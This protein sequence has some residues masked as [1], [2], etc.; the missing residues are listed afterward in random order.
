M[1]ILFISSGLMPDYQCDSLFHG[2]REVFGNGV[3]DI[4]KV[5]YMYKTFPLSEKPNLYGKGFT[6]YGLLEDESDIDRSDIESKIKHRFFDFI[7]Y[8]SIHRCQ[9]YVE[10]VL[11]IYPPENI[12]FIDGE[13]DGKV[14]N[15]LLNRG[16]YFKRELQA[17]N[18][19]ILPIHFSVPKDK[20]IND[21]Y[22]LEKLSFRSH[23][24]PR[25]R[26]TYIYEKEE[27]YYQQYQESFFGF[28]TKKAGW[29]CLRHYEI[30][31]QGCAP[32]FPDLLDCPYLTM[33]RF[34]RLETIRLMEIA[35]YCVQN[36]YLDMEGYLSNLEYLF[37]YAKKYLTTAAVA[38]YV[39]EQLK[40]YSN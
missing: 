27:D 5:E 18:R 1:N 7:V 39:I 4:N 37:N 6:L 31:A 14:I 24:D 26:S 21:I 35:D 19:F 38:S 29:D 30:I 13:D 3:V 11:D 33:H 22:E 12:V 8:G 25:D 23:C 10:T 36:E 32:Y 28:T 17:E 34:P 9:T 40:S 15:L 20:F 2:L 16:F